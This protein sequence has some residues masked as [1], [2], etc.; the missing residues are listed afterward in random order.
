[1]K[2]H[3]LVVFDAFTSIARI[4]CKNINQDIERLVKLTFIS[5]FKVMEEFSFG[6]FQ[7]E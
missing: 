3:Q 5:F 1:M 6:I 7:N 4:K 2:P